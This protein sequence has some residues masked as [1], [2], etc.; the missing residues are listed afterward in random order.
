MN[1]HTADLAAQAYRVG[2]FGRE[3]FTVFDEHWYA[4]HA[5]PGYGLLF[6][7]LAWLIGM[8]VAAALAVMCSI[9]LFESLT[10]RFYGTAGGAGDALETE[11]PRARAGR[12][13]GKSHRDPDTP[14]AGLVA[15]GGC[16]FA[17]AAVGDVWS[18]RLTFAFGVAFGVACVFA[19]A[20]GR[21]AAGAALAGVCAAASPVA[22]LLLALAALSQ[23]IARRRAGALALVG[24][25]VALVLGPLELL[26]AE[27]G[28]EPFPVRSFAASAAVTLA[29]LWG[30]PRGDRLLRVGGVVYLLALAGTLL[31]HSAMGS[32]IERYGVLLGGPLLLCSLGREA[33]RRAAPRGAG[34]A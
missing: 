15:A 14:G 23:A 11:G 21:R 4:G 1:P 17:V 20:R 12:R 3:G 18:G 13:F 28:L 8:R 31:A 9:A 29:F 27:G 30:V 6:A 5:M 19:L 32:N 10:R 24:A 34:K 26:F 7:P 2:L 16:L 33:A 22:G 25:P